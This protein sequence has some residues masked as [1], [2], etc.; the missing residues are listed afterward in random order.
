MSTLLEKA[1]QRQKEQN[2]SGNLYLSDKP[3]KKLM[4]VYNGRKIH[5]GQAGSSTYLE[6][7]DNDKRKAYRARH[8]KIIT[9]EGI[10]AYK[11]RYTPSWC[12]WMILW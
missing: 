12:S 7:G 3:D 2:I 1:K 6:N 4:L 9:I 11:K 5:F 10:P 8:S